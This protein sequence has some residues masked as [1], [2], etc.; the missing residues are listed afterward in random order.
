MPLE[1]VWTWRT[2][3]SRRLRPASPIRRLRH[4]VGCDKPHA[5]QRAVPALRALRK[6]QLPFLRL[7][8]AVPPASRL[9]IETGSK[10]G[11]TG[12]GGRW[13]QAMQ[14]WSAW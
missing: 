9:S 13:R 5:Q 11:G 8:T 7:V 3:G 12:G 14:F 1:P 4:A 10:H 6:S 2:R